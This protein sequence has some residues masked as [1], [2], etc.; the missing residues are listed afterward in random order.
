VEKAINLFGG[1]IVRCWA[2]WFKDQSPAARQAALAELADLTPQQAR[3][4]VAAAV[5]HLAPSAAAADRARAVEY[6]VAIPLSVKRSLVSDRSTGRRALPASLSAD[7]PSSLLQLLPIDVPPYQAPTALAGTD[8]R[9]EE[10]L[11]SGGFGAVYRA[12]SPSLQHLPLAIKFCLDPK[13]VP[14]LQ[15]ERANLE[16][17]MKAGGKSWSPRL[18]RLYGYDLE[19]RTP[20]LVY[21]YVPGG[22]LVHRLA[23]R[24]ARDGHGL[25]ADE[26]LRLIVQVA[27]ALAVAHQRG[28]VHRDLKPA[29]VLIG[30]GT[31]KLADFGISEVL[32]RQAVKTSRIGTVAA[33]RLS[34]AEQASLFRG[35][36]TPLYMAPEQR[37]GEPPDLRHDLYSLGVMWYQLLVGDVTREMSHGW[38]RELE[39]KFDVPGQH[40][41]LIEK[42]VG[43][44]DDRPADA[45]EL[46]QLLGLFQGSGRTQSRAVKEV[47]PPP[48]HPVPAD[49]ESE[50]SRH[51]RFITG[52]RQL[53]G[54][55][56]A[57][58]WYRE[59]F[60]PVLQGILLG[61]LLASAGGFA[62]G[63]VLG[64]ASLGILF[65]FLGGLGLWG[66]VYWL[67]L[68]AR[69]KDSARAEQNL[70]ARIEQLLSEF[71]Q[72]CQTW[73][74]GAA[75]ADRAVVELILRELEGPQR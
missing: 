54:R 25:T 72:E 62:G 67:R 63:L 8:Y 44:I 56:Q 35:A 55:H 50:R 57:V 2:D 10:L 19:H 46:V 3:T 59:P 11:G 45:G 61:L 7:D 66:T 32:S 75:L 39:A 5:E 47:V 23:A 58:A 14:A 38:A 74:G 21:E 31:I 26:A 27:E 4:A 37:R 69:D 60:A 34:A 48:E 71:P 29:N 43:G 15:Q 18:V 41:N 42:C 64:G 22:D 49:A 73:G 13:L 12:S 52:M 9:L 20:Y 1:P 24:Q 68:R 53:R 36:G 65:G 30:D 17:L 28:L 33:S 51:L 16:R 70:A 40:I 6:L